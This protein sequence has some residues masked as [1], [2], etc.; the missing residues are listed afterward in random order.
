[1]NQSTLKPWF[2]GKPTEITDELVAQMKT[3]HGEVFLYTVEDKKALFKRPDR[4]AASLAASMSDRDPLGSNE[5]LAKNTFLAGDSDIV[6]V[7]RYFYGLGSFLQQL[8]PRT[9]GE[10][11]EL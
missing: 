5:V 8:I 6:E 11:K 1:M 9:M 7:D 2:E 10:L 3:K 4:K